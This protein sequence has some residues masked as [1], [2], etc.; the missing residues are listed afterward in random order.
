[1]DG[2]QRSREEVDPF[3]E[4]RPL[5]RVEQGEPFVGSDLCGI[6]FDLREVGLPCGIDRGVRQRIPFHVHAGIRV[7]L[8]KFELASQPVAWRRRLLRGCERRNH[9]MR[10]VRKIRETGQLARIADEAIDVARQPGREEFVSP[11]SWIVSIEEDPPSRLE[12]VGVAK[13][14]ERDANLERPAGGSDSSGRVPIEIGRV[15]LVRDVAGQGVVLH[16]TRIGEKHL[17]RLAVVAAVHDHSPIV[18]RGRHV[19]MIRERRAD[20]L[21]L[22]IVEAKPCVEVPVVVREVRNVAY[23][24]FD[25]VP[26]VRLEPGGDSFDALPPRIR[27]LAV[28]VD[29]AGRAANGQGRSRLGIRRPG[30]ARCHDHEHR[31]ESDHEG[32]H[33][34]RGDDH[35]SRDG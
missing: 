31:E 32:P 11:I 17:G 10:A 8:A 18:G 2:I 6:R 29:R 23:L 15:V 1:M 34:G 33:V 7:E 14:G 25:V 27:E 28:Q 21:G 3:E 24:R 22:R 26:D 30:R 19:I 20:E 13:R 5:L 4:E 9:Q 35:A 16:A 12:L